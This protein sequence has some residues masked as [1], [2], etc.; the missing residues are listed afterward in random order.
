M[1]MS[2]S[3]CG[4]ALGV[5]VVLVLVVALVTIRTPVGSALMKS[6]ASFRP[7][8]SD[9][10]VRF[11]PGAD[12]MADLIVA[13]LDTAVAKVEDAQGG[14]FV[15][16]IT[17]FVCATQRS[18]NEF[19]AL[20]PDLPVRGTVLFGDVYIAPSAYDWMGEDVHRQSLMHEL[21]HL[22]LRQRLGWLTARGSIP[23]WFHEALADQVSGAGGEGVS[24]ARAARAILRGPALKPDSTG[25]LWTL[26]RVGNY[27]LS[28]PML[29][30]QG[31]L[32][33]DYL[34]GRDP[35]GYP[36]FVLAIQEQ[37]SFAKPFRDHFGGGVEALWHDFVESLAREEDHGAK[38][39]PRTHRGGQG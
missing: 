4:K 13:F 31:Q 23:P 7:H 3:P 12:R 14:P 25:N 5:L 30:R 6:R 21:S 16:P 1:R 29:H 2:V 18:L 26:R 27:G 32:F 15:R 28:G 11:E 38:E 36:G 20:P 37:R 9:S 39:E 35:E 17:V 24:R 33:I 22:H 34:R 19:T 8:P 10:R